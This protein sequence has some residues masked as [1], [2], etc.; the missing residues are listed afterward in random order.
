MSFTATLTADCQSNPAPIKYNFDYPYRF[1]ENVCLAQ[2]NNSYYAVT[3]D[4]SNDAR[5]FV[6]TGV[7][8]MLYA[9]FIIFVYGY[10]DELY[11]SKMEIPM[12]DF[13]LTTIFAILWLSAS[14]AWANGSLVLKNVF[15][16]DVVRSKCN[17]CIISNSGFNG[18]NTS[19]VSF[20]RHLSKFING[21][22]F[23]F[24][25]GYFKF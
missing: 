8:S 20:Q 22:L 11:K 14:A 16:P 17:H 2:G 23:E 1:Y 7:L 13:M 21:Q 10:L 15:D 9:I 3:A 24:L 18:L 19:I 25:T 5:F 6:A 12:A 4:V